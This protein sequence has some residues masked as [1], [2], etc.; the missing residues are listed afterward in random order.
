MR[1]HKTFLS[2]IVS[3]A[4]PCTHPVSSASHTEQTPPH[5][6]VFIG[7]GRAMTTAK[8]WQ[9]RNIQP[10]A[11]NDKTLSGAGFIVYAIT[12][13]QGITKDQPSVSFVVAGASSLPDVFELWDTFRE[14]E[15]PV[16]AEKV[17]KFVE[18]LRWAGYVQIEQT[19]QMMMGYD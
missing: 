12:I 6:V 9:P 2:V 17:E 3:F 1:L 10:I 16:N 15:H 14:K 8:D 4:T 11:V 5:G 13:E 18:F 7:E 19:V